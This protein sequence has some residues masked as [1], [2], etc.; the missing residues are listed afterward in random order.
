LS[1]V[2]DDAT[3]HM[4]EFTKKSY[5]QAGSL[6]FVPHS[7]SLDIE[8]RLRLDNKPSGHPSHQRSRNL[9]SMSERT[10]IHDRPTPGFAV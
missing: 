6:I 3:E 8:F 1:G 10:S 7:G 5:A 2:I 4:R 9:R